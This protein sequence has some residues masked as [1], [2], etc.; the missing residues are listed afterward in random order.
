MS[1]LIEA[2]RADFSIENAKK[3]QA[4]ERKHPMV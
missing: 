3:I 1:K 4:Y 2:Y